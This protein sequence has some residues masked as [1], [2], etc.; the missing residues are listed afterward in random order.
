[1]I[2]K[3]LCVILVTGGLLATGRLAASALV[4]AYDPLGATTAMLT[5]LGYRVCAWDG[6]VKTNQLVCIGRGAW[7]VSTTLLPKL[8]AHVTNGGRALIFAQSDAVLT[9]VFRF[10]IG[11]YIA[12]RMFPVDDDHPVVRGL[13]AE[14]LRDWRGES[15]LLDPYPYVPPTAGTV[16]F[17]WRWG[18]RGGV[19]SVPIEQPHR[20]G[21]RPILECEFDLAYAA[22]MELELGSGVVVWCPCDLEDH[23]WEDPGARVLARRIIEYTRTN[24]FRIKTGSAHYVGDAAGALL[25][26]NTLGAIC[27]IGNSL[28]TN[29]R[30]NIIG[31]GAGIS[32]TDVVNYLSAGGRVVFLARSSDPAYGLGIRLGLQNTFGWTQPVTGW[33]EAAGLGASDLRFRT[34]L[35]TVLVT[36]GWEHAAGGQLART[37]IGAGVAVWCQIDPNRFNADTLTYFRFS[38]WRQTRALAQ[39]LANLGVTF[40]MDRAIFAPTSVEGYYHPVIS[41]ASISAMIPT[42]V[43]GGSPHG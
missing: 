41:P 5:R 15:R 37:N 36:G 33:V 6:G 1:M 34:T 12:R 23:Y 43:I 25:V 4:Y 17:G 16:R 9:D 39:V 11:R 22:L 7:G 24:V 2:L 8:E 30:V 26:T 38:R 10:R 13:D 14:D 28:K 18:G 42:E 20:T 35:N 40:R 27:T 19:C 31:P 21:W 29:A 3:H 32:G